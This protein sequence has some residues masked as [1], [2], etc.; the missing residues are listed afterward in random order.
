[1]R[2]W[3]VILLSLGA[4]Q[5][6]DVS[7]VWQGTLGEGTDRVRLRLRMAR[8][9]DRW[10]GTLFSIDQSLDWG[11]GQPLS[12]VKVHAKS[13][14]FKVDEKGI[15]GGFEG[16][17]SPNRA[18]IVGKWIQGGFPQPLEFDRPTKK[19][20]WTDPV[21]H[22]VQFTTVDYGVRLEILDWGGAGP[23]L[24][25]LAG[26]GNSAHVFDGLRQS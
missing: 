20:E 26:L 17:L 12:S 23:P 5:A 10:V 2:A 8:V 13:L 16:T 21:R 24:V 11:I 22:S 25:L 9:H 6:Q 7:G 3:V 15:F 1:M 19:T 4:L 14:T 18:S